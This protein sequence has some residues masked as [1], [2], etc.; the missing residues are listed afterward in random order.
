MDKNSTTDNPLD[1]TP[2]TMEDFYDDL[3]ELVINQARN[4]INLNLYTK[5]LLSTLPVALIATNTDGIV[6]TL[7]QAAEEILGIREKI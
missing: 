7:N 4:M 1:I 6:K 5:S 2:N 3:Q